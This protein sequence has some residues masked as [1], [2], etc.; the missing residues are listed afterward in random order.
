MTA[1]T[2]QPLMPLAPAQEMLWEF[3]S[4]LAAPDPALFTEVAAGCRLIRGILDADLFQRSVAAV[5]ARNENLRMVFATLGQ[6]PLLRPESG[7]EPP[8]RV[9][10]LSRL[11]RSVQ[12]ERIAELAAAERGAGFDVTKGPLWRAGLVRL[13]PAEHVLTYTFCHLVADGWGGT[14][15]AE[16]V[17]NAYRA[18]TGSGPRPSGQQLRFAQLARLQHEQLGDKQQRAAYWRAQLARPGQPYLPFPPDTVAAD[19]DVAAE[20]VHRFRFPDGACEGIRRLAW[21]L[22]TTPFTVLLAAHHLL[23]ALRADM[24]RVVI[25]TTVLGRDTPRARRV[26]GQ[27]TTDVYVAVTVQPADSL[28]CVARQAHLAFTAAT[29]NALSYLCLAEAVNPRFGRQRP[30]PDNHLF[31]AYIQ[32]VQPAAP[33]VS[34]QDL[35]MTDLPI[36]GRGASPVAAGIAARDVP[37]SRLAVWAKRGAPDIII[38][39][40]RRGGVIAHNPYFYSE[41]FARSLVFDYLAIVGALACDPG[42]SVAQL[43]K[44]L[45][46]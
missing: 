43:K 34:F 17:L 29:D 5:M 26:I 35:E 28:A 25:G 44:G 20:A 45:K 27:F 40:D 15:F 32:S 12:Q 33:A 14:V 24:D 18:R 1:V 4:A 3:N 42:Q 6:D 22:R 41:K 8:V 11:P 30:W 2:G 46:R 23:L 31:D 16:A 13:G 9:T 7:L 10:D 19:A 39:H 37:A 21:R 38:D 36:T